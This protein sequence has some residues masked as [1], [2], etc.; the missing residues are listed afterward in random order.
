MIEYLSRDEILKRRETI[1]TDDY[2]GNETL[3]VV[4]VEEILEVEPADVVE[5]SK[6]DKAIEEMKQYILEEECNGNHE[7]GIMFALEILERNIG[8]DE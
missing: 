7:K 6:I 3:D 8:E 2:S 5:R 4:A 1:V